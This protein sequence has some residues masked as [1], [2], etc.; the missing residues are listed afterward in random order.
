LDKLAV[1]KKSFSEN[2]KWTKS[3]MQEKSDFINIEEKVEKK[4]ETA[5]AATTKKVWTDEEKRQMRIELQKKALRIQMNINASLKTNNPTQKDS[6]DDDTDQSDDEEPGA[7]KIDESGLE[8]DLKS[9]R[10]QDTDD[11]RAPS[12]AQFEADSLRNQAFDDMLKEYEKNI[13]RKNNEVVAE[14]F[15]IKD[16]N[17]KKETKSVKWS[18][19]IE[20]NES[21]EDDCD[22]DD[23]EDDD[24]L[25]AANSDDKENV[26]PSTKIIKI[27]HTTNSLIEEKIRNRKVSIDKAD[28]NLTPGDIFN[29]F[30]KPKSI[31]KQRTHS[32]GGEERSATT[33]PNDFVLSN[34]GRDYHLL[35]GGGGGGGGE[36]GGDQ[37]VN[38]PAQSSDKSQIINAENEQFEPLKA[39]TGE[40]IEKTF[41]KQDNDT[42]EDNPAKKPISRFKAS[43]KN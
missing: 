15:K 14:S 39:F 31:L 27:N 1:E 3:V 11:Q 30:Y 13:D 36:G 41:A 10:L 17:V 9:L 2:V 23:D 18:D 40:I 7:L 33:Q 6:D 25:N 4:A 12:T 35:G 8:D 38:K 16:T 26:K 42:I 28:E 29:V 5:P 32:G 34:S 19:A 22:D 21:D 37:E 20:D 24:D 43:R